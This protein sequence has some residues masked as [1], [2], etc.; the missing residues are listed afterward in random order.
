[1]T[2]YRTTPSSAPGPSP[3]LPSLAEVA[4]ARAM[5]LTAPSA[6]LHPLFEQIAGAIGAEALR[7][8]GFAGP[9]LY[10]AALTCAIAA[11]SGLARVFVPDAPVPLLMLCFAAGSVYGIVNVV[12]SAI[13][14]VDKRTGQDVTIVQPFVIGFGLGLLA[15]GV[16]QLLALIP[17]I[18]SVVP[19]VLLAI[20]LFAV[21][22]VR[23][24]RPP[25]LRFDGVPQV[26]MTRALL[27]MADPATP[28]T[29]VWNDPKA[30]P[31][32]G[33]VYQASVVRPDSLRITSAFYKYPTGPTLQVIVE[34]PASYRWAH[35][36]DSVTFDGL[37][38]DVSRTASSVVVRA[39]NT[40]GAATGKLFQH[41]LSV[42]LNACKAL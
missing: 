41:A 15:F 5:V 40:Q 27:K 38:L 3:A 12:T 23:Y 26:G 29:V 24:R 20:G 13:R 37:T 9:V 16:D 34:F 11:A 19:D 30:L 36:S 25:Q 7:D 21:W 39:R 17:V 28:T 6:A 8:M 10:G 32:D 22:Y 14:Y 4:G 18:P 1:M 33:L 42:A 35:A 31:P 2:A